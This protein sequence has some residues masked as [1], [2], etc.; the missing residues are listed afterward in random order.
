VNDNLVNEFE[1]I[2]QK[3]RDVIKKKAAKVCV[4]ASTIRVFP[5]NSS[6]KIKGA[7]LRVDVNRMLR[8][9]NPKDFKKWFEDELTK[10]ARAIP[11]VTRNKK[12]NK[13]LSRGARY[14]GYGAKILN[15]YLRDIVIHNHYFTDAQVERIQDLLYVPLDSKVIDKL[16]K[17]NVHL[18]F[19]KIKEIDNCDKFYQVQDE[20]GRAADKAGAPRIWFDYVWAEDPKERKWR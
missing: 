16:K 5:K 19:G 11:K 1:R 8:I 6:S 18:D 14:W 17:L 3:I 7:L 12:K 4:G 15:L 9:K 2:K 10:V 13:K 20:L